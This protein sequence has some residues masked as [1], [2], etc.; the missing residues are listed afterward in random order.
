MSVVRL[1]ITLPEELAQDLNNIVKPK[2]KSRFIAEALKQRL[3]K[4]RYDS[5]RDMLEEGYR[6]RKDESHS[7]SKEFEQTDLEGWDEY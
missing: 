2:S 1:N 5:L 7:L 6:A 4:I 3:E